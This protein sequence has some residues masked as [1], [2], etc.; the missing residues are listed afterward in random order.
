MAKK[1]DENGSGNVAVLEK[2]EEA[3]IDL[4]NASQPIGIRLVLTGISPLVTD[5]FPE[6]DAYNVLT[7]GKR[8]EKDT[9]SSKEERCRKK[10]YRNAD[11]KI[12]MPADNV[13]SCLVGAGKRVKFQGNTKVSNSSG[14]WLA[15]FLT[16]LDNEHLLITPEGKGVD[17]EGWV[18]DISVGRL[19]SNGVA[20]AL[21][22]PRFDEWSFIANFEYDPGLAPQMTKRVVLTLFK[23]AGRGLGLG[24][25]NPAHKGKK[26]MFK[27]TSWKEFE[28][29]DDLD[30]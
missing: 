12:I 17:G 7:L 15:L 29:K 19:P 6:E 3:V 28:I 14:T 26:G 16:P 8:P 9:E 2:D 5:H 25:H 20:N 27:V 18:P 1:K 21:I 10:I 13:W 4:S 22:R 30:D 23:I 24:S 11:G